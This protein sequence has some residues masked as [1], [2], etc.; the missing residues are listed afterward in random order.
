LKPIEALPLSIHNL[1][2]RTHSNF[3]RA[4]ADEL[5]TTSLDCLLKP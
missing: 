5:V 1:P 4:E 3:L 2:S